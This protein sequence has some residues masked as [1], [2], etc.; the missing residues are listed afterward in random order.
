VHDTF[1]GPDVRLGLNASRSSHLRLEVPEKYVTGDLFGVPLSDKKIDAL[2]KKYPDD[3]KKPEAPIQISLIDGDEGNDG[4]ARGF[5]AGA[6]ATTRR[7]IDMDSNTHTKSVG[8]AQGQQRQRNKVALQGYAADRR[9]LDTALD[10]DTVATLLDVGKKRSR[11]DPAALEEMRKQAMTQEMMAQRRRPSASHFPP[12]ICP[13][14]PSHSVS[15]LHRSPPHRRRCPSAVRARRR[16]AGAH[17]AEEK[18]GRRAPLTPTH[19]ERVAR[20]L[21][22]RLNFTSRPIA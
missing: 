12:R 20:A 1:R 8:L 9:Q 6:S 11:E 15:S 3:F 18:R 10:E 16:H 22:R 14:S 13:A 19:R 17:A 2:M 5:S 21:N 4:G 7:E